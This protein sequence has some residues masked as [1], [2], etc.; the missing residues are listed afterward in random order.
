VTRAIAPLEKA[1]GHPLTTDDVEPATLGAMLNGLKVTNAGLAEANKVLGDTAARY[2][3]Q[4]G[5]MDIYM[6][7]TLSA[8]PVKIGILGPAQSWVERSAILFDYGSYC[9]LDNVS[10]T[11]AITLPIGFSHAGLPVGIQFA[12]RPGGERRLLELAYQLE[13]AVRW[14]DRRPPVWVA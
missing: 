8:E 14:T 11:P 4:F 7:P 2:T 12:T 3:A 6:T 13:S 5:D 1:V 10:G 9:W